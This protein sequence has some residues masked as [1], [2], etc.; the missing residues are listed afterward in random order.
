M[1]TTKEY[2]KE[3]EKAIEIQKLWKPKVGDFFYTKETQAI[4][5]ITH[6]CEDK[7]VI[8]NYLTIQWAQSLELRNIVGIV[9]RI[10]WIKKHKIWLPTQDRLWNM[11][12]IEPYLLI[13]EFKKWF[14]YFFER[15][16]FRP[17]P[18]EWSMERFC[19]NF[20]MYRKYDKIFN[21]KEWVKIE[22]KNILKKGGKKEWTKIKQ[23]CLVERNCRGLG[24]VLMN[25]LI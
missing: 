9:G 13:D 16:Y 11:I 6:I 10:D 14:D 1:D 24:S 21:G 17:T 23:K 19:L 3:C 20:V 18:E 15:L 7:V 12:G 8:A 5:I 22:E 25:L 4:G 2:I